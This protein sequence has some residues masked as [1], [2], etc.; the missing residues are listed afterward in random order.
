[1][2]VLG[3]AK[4]LETW[5]LEPGGPETYYEMIARDKEIVKVTSYVSQCPVIYRWNSIHWC[6][7]T[8]FLDSVTYG[9]SL[10]AVFVKDQNHVDWG[11]SRLTSSN[12]Q[13][14]MLC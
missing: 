1:M 12:K 7:S 13:V 2:Q 14:I 11:P 4:H 8:I 9:F 5:G 6:T 10:V 3:V